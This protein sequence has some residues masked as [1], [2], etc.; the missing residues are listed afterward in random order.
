MERL[1][2]QVLE[3]TYELEQAR[4]VIER[5]QDNYQQLVNKVNSP[6]HRLEFNSKENKRIQ[7]SLVG[8][9]PMSSRGAQMHN[10]S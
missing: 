8:R 6:C 10:D 4:G 3:Q 1:E 9:P 5:Q 2:R 7:Y